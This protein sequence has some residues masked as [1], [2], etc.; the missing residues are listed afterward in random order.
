MALFTSEGKARNG[1]L[2]TCETRQRDLTLY[3]ILTILIKTDTRS[4]DV[5]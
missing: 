4:A 1:I 2:P 3:N 5:N